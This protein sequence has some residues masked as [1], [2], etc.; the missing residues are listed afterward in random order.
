[1]HGTGSALPVITAL[2]RAGQSDGLTDAVEERR[3]RVDPKLAVLSVDAQRDG[4]RA[5]DVRPC[6]S[7][8]GRGALPGRAVRVLR[9]APRNDRSRRASCRLEKCPAGWF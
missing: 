3:P 7:F 4:D 9:S 1:M 8:R 2:L 5:F 6:R